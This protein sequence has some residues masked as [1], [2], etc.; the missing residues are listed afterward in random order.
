MTLQSFRYG[1]AAAVEVALVGG[2]SSFP[3]IA[4]RWLGHVPDPDLVGMES[5]HQGGPGRATSSAVVEL[6]KTHA[7][8]GQSV[9]VR[10]V[11]F[12]AMVTEVGEPHVVHHDE[13]D[14]GALG[15]DGTV[16]PKGTNE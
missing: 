8:L 1:Y 14:V 9:E 7:P 15:G 3:A 6:G 16:R 12:T 10:G 5:G 2:R 11:D 4:S 13:N